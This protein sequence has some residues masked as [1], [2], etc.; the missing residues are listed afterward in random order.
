VGT[1][2]ARRGMTAAGWVA[3]AAVALAVVAGLGLA[4]HP[5]YQSESQTVS[6]SGA[7]TS[8]SDGATLLEE[9]GP[10]VALL[11][12]VPV[13]LAAL[14]LGGAIR[15][16]KTLAWVSAGVLL[17]FCVVG[18]FSIGLF[19]LPAGLSLLVAAGLCRPDIRSATATT[20]RS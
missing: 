12:C 3:L 7:V 5:V 19:Y 20:P 8:S 11:L 9:N 14:G 13:V 2:D 18:G 6:S 10:W 17:A 16:R 4:F 1:P 15:G